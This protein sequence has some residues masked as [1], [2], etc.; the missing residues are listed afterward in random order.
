[1]GLDQLQEGVGSGLLDTGQRL[2]PATVRKLACDAQVV[3]ALLG[4]D[5][6][7]LDLGR[8]SRT[9]TS[10]QRRALGLRDGNGC[11]FPGCDRPLVW[12]E[13]HHIRYW[14]D[15]GS[16]DLANLALLCRAHHRAVHE[17]DW[18]LIRGPD[19]RVTATPPYRR[20]PG[21]RRHPPAA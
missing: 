7:P 20:Q 14:I 19:G 6:H 21:A 15:G 16:T 10:A 12:C 5:G 1:M 17:G 4:T 13:G 11:A 2:S 8:S 18:Q 3:P 9:F